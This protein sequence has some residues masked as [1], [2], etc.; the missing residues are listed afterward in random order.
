MEE[1]LERTKKN[2]KEEEEPKTMKKLRQLKLIEE[3]KQIDTKEEF[4]EYTIKILAD[5]YLPLI[6]FEDHLFQE[7]FEAAKRL[8]IEN[9]PTHTT[10]SKYL[11]DAF[12]KTKEKIKNELNGWVSALTFDIW[13]ISNRSFLLINATKLS[14]TFLIQN[15]NL[16]IAAL[17]DLAHTSENLVE[18]IE[19]VKLEYE[20]DFVA[21]YLGDNAR[22][23]K[24]TVKVLGN[25]NI[26]IDLEDNNTEFEFLK[27]KIKSLF[28]CNCHQINL[29]AHWTSKVIN[30][31]IQFFHNLVLQCRVAFINSILKFFHYS[32]LNY[33]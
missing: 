25:Q 23:M 31:D 19:K 10:L 24:K 20:I 17:N 9:F 4:Y 7:L 29:V 3:A 26:E 11:L 6:F 18:I 32:L 1:V 5:K 21:Q 14:S 28:G 30:G 22:N 27:Q 12:A 8:K 2:K 13:S 15:Y 33:N 16:A